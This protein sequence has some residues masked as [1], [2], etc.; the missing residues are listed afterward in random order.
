MSQDSDFDSDGSISSSSTDS[1]EDPLGE[2]VEGRICHFLGHLEAIPINREGTLLQ[3][4]HAWI[5]VTDPTDSEFSVLNSNP[6][7]PKFDFCYKLPGPGNNWLARTTNGSDGTTELFETVQKHS[8]KGYKLHVYECVHQRASSWI[9]ESYL[10]E[11]KMKRVP[12]GNSLAWTLQQRLRFEIGDAYGRHPWNGPS[13]Y[14]ERAREIW[15]LDGDEYDDEDERL[16]RGENLEEDEDEDYEVEDDEEAEDD[17]E[18]DDEG[19][20]E[21]GDGES[22]PTFGAIWQSHMD[23]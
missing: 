3:V 17:E 6:H 18:S 16:D 2:Y 23:A 21:D 4:H 15:A 13:K 10:K 12:E 22:V 19:E 8:I 14:N 9:I 5:R 20:D 1:D 11:T 7:G